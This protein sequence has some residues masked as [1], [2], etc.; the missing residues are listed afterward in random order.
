MELE[1]EEGGT[2]LQF[3]QWTAA[4]IGPELSEIK[5]YTEDKNQ[6]MFLTVWGVENSYR[7]RLGEADGSEFWEQDTAAV[8]AAA[9][10]ARVQLFSIW[11]KGLWAARDE[12]HSCVLYRRLWRTPVFP[13]HLCH[14]ASGFEM[15]HAAP[16]SY[17]HPF[18][19]QSLPWCLSCSQPQWAQHGWIPS[20][21]RDLYTFEARVPLASSKCCTKSPE[22]M[23]S[24]GEATNEE[25][26]ME[27]T[28]LALLRNTCRLHL[29]TQGCAA[30]TLQSF[31][32]WQTHLN[33]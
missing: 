25:I 20:C 5:Y 31:R 1:L 26:H 3:S 15:N 6:G 23:P 18:P 14:S 9:A 12:S 13:F 2:T 17:K 16:T 10:T 29:Q 30:A 27:A 8:A 32:I 21:R 28:F 19:S 24:W 7:L 33:L 11:Q 4:E 22:L